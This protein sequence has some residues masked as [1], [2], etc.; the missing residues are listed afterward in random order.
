MQL[1]RV[2]LS[3]V[4][5]ALQ[6]QL[7]QPISIADPAHTYLLSYSASPLSDDTVDIDPDPKTGLLTTI[8]LTAADRTDDIIIEIAKSAAL[9]F[10]AA[11]EPQG[12]EIFSRLLD[13]S[14]EAA[15]RELVDDMNRVAIEDAAIQEQSACRAPSDERA[16][17]ICTGYRS[18]AAGLRRI[19]LVIDE[20][21]PYPT[22]VA[23]CS[24]GVCYR[25][26]MP[27]RFRVEF[28]GTGYS[29]EEVHSLTNAMPPIPIDLA[30]A[31]FVT[32]VTK[33]D[34]DAGQVDKVHV[35]KPSE[36]LELASLPVRVV[37][38][39]F[40]A[41]ADLIQLRVNVGTKEQAL[42]QQE[43]QVLQAKQ[44]LE[45]AKR[46][47]RVTESAAQANTALLI[48]RSDGGHPRR[49]LPGFEDAVVRSR[50]PL[51]DSAP[52]PAQDGTGSGQSTP[53]NS[54]SSESGG[55]GG[56]TE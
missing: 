38:A 29:V 53:S 51:A 11:T 32:K 8:D 42:A 35:Q 31:S 13:P 15:K 17:A 43:L 7:D 10:E 14:D 5:G 47:Q 6:V 30:R 12:R 2:R 18:V 26:A 20:P 3:D 39:F 19:D 46:Q 40:G 52:P 41:V 37:S 27:Y 28:E 22:P 25:L 49:A 36:A 56:V 4:E 48:A 21:P 16:R 54:G 45:D 23:D 33:I 44:A 50:A 1:V 55:G 34:F 24:I 9:I